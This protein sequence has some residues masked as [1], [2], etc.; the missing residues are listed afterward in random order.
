MENLFREYLWNGKMAKISLRVLQNS[1]QEG[2]LGLVNLENKEKALKATWP[3]ILQNESR[4][5]QDSVPIDKHVELG[6]DIWRCN[7]SK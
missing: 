6:E 1:K 3:R 5:Q 7:L 4:I 2:G